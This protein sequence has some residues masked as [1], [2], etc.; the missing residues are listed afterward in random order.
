MNRFYNLI[1]KDSAVDLSFS[2]H[3]S[4]TSIE[5]K[6][7]ESVAINGNVSSSALNTKQE[8]VITV[9]IMDLNE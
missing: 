3:Y 6:P 4:L 2:S 7:S 1:N 9:N 5:L 8:P